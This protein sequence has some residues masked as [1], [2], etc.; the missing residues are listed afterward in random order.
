MK[1]VTTPTRPPASGNEQTKVATSRRR[2]TSS[3]LSTL[4]T[5][6]L[7]ILTV[8]LIVLFSILLPDTFPTQLTL[9]SI[10]STTSII[11]LLALAEMM[12]AAIG[13]ID[14]SVG[15]GIG[16]AHILAI[17]LITRSQLPWGLVVVIVLLVGAFIGLINGLLV[18]VAKIDSFI[19]TLGV[20][21]VIYGLS[22]WYT[23]GQQI[24]GT[25]PNGFIAISN[26]T[27]FGIPAPAIY[28][29]IIA[30]VLWIAF[31]FLPVGRYLYALGSNARA[32]ELSG[33]PRTRYVIGAFVAGGLLT[34]FAGIV[35]ASRLQVGQSNVGPDYLLPAIV[36]ALLGATTIRP[37]RVNVW[38]TIIAI[39]LLAVGVAGIEQFGAAF[40]VDSL[41]NGL[42]LVIAVGLAGYAARRRLQARV[43]EGR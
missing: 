11:A 20:G 9:A 15:Y 19:A 6:G 2:S 35:L 3:L 37:G 39:L 40:F 34:A 17:G 18:Q 43:K 21:T 4:G 33:I 14:L 38:G 26:T 24:V 12:V 7:P 29:A 22:N 10:L 41:F 32:A 23:N 28:V 5:Y 31:E 25:I 13:Q 16:I 8:L 1:E 27:L 30:V 42:T 36:G